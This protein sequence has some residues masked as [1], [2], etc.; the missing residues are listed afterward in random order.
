MEGGRLA[1]EA[2]TA[3]LEAAFVLRPLGK[4]GDRVTLFRVKSTWLGCVPRPFVVLAMA[5]LVALGA[6]RLA[7]AQ[8]SGAP[9]RLPEE[10]TLPADGIHVTPYL[11]YHD[12][13]LLERARVHA[14]PMTANQA[15]YDVR[16]YDLNLQP[17]PS[18][19]IL[20]G[21]VRVLASVTAGP[22]TTLELDLASGPLTV[23]AVTCAGSPATFT[24]ASDLLTINLDRPYATGETMDVTV[25]YH[26]QPQATGFGSFGFSTHGGKSL[27]W[28]LSEP[29][30]AHSWWPCKDQPDDKADSVDV[31]VTVPTGMITAGNGTRVEYTD[32]G[33]TSFTHWRERYP[34]ASYLVSMTCFAYST[35]SDWY[36]YTPTDSMEIKFFYYPENVA[37]HSTVS[38]KVKGMIA[39]Y[40]A[41][42]GQYPFLNEKYGHA[43]FPFGG[44][45]E[46]QTCTSLGAFGEYVVAHELGHQW[47]GD[48]VTCED[49]HHIW[50][51]EG[52]ATYLESVWAE[53][54]GGSSLYRTHL[55]PNRYYGS[56]TIYCPDLS[57]V[58]RIFDTNL[59]YDKP[60]WVL[61]MLRHVLGDST[62]FT[63]MHAYRDKFAYSTATTEGFEGVME[64]FYGGSLGKFF[65][66]WI[67]GEYYPIY[68]WNY[69]AAPSGGGYDVTVNLAQTQSWQ[70][71][72][73][74]VDV[75][76]QAGGGSTTFVAMDSLPAQ[77]FT[78]HV[79]SAPTSVL[80]DPNE[81]ILRQFDNTTDVGVRAPITSLELA[82]PWPNP[83]RDGAHLEFALPRAG[84]LHA[85]VV[86]A[87][88]RRVVKL[89]DGPFVAGR[90][91]LDWDGRDGDGV[92]VQDGIYWATVEQGGARVARKM[93]VLR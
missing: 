68:R 39:A 11:S 59:T 73:M 31:R 67:Y 28:T 51:N 58:N 5:W 79:A 63:A 32:N 82:R 14:I 84:V 24:H 3:K 91:G 74:P 35:Y 77:P 47:F 23:D 56:G 44:G 52:F 20:T 72:W 43:E 61:H 37:A 21:A 80:I 53:V 71:F 89:A 69:S 54:N 83:C 70:I 27:I 7:A 93:V 85:F 90:H 8:D 4:N 1:A 60:S 64:S 26:G 6:A 42:F 65:Q 66:E 46:H 62:F 12:A 86:D 38:A 13:R 50:L 29:F 33:T 34:I 19:Q 88:G 45:M 78:F 76:I 15:S 41:R 75:T 55:N 22:L 18:T 40:A 87:A 81:W 17:N 30:G 2:S 49:F 16:Y 10:P 57:D 9:R 25:S 36:R 48:L 92:P